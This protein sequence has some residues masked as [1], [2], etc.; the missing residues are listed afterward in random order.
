MISIILDKDKN[1]EVPRFGVL[2]FILAL[3]L[4]GLMTGRDRV[5]ESNAGY[6][7][8]AVLQ[9]EAEKTWNDLIAKREELYKGNMIVD[10]KLGEQIYNER[11][12][13]CHSFDKKILGPPYN[14]VLPKYIDKQ[15][16]L[17]AFI[18]NPR[19]INPQYPSMPNQGL[20]TIGIKSV[21]KFLM[22]KIGAPSPAEPGEKKK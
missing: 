16:E 11:C 3:V 19:K 2:C 8:A 22:K 20:T 7:S 1:A 4:S 13:A 17:I 9:T 15:D 21:V 5:L 12:S 14:T 6:E 10:E 18:K